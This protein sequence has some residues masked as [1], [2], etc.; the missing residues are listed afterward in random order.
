MG[1]GMTSG[2]RAYRRRA[3]A[4]FTV[5][6]LLFAGVI[7]LYFLRH[8][9]PPLQVTLALVISAAIYLG[10]YFAAGA[11]PE[12]QGAI[13]RKALII[14]FALYVLLLLNFTIFDDYFGRSVNASESGFTLSEYFE[15][16]ANLVPFR[17]I[18]RQ[19][20]ALVNGRYSVGFFIINILGNLAAL[21]PFALFLPAL[22]KK[23]KKWPRFLIVMTAIIFTIETLQFFTR[24]GSLDIDDYILNLSGAAAAFALVSTKRGKRFIE[25]IMAPNKTT[26]DKKV[27]YEE[28][29]TLQVR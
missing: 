4:C 28:D 17:M 13:M 3:A 24:T 9:S 16:K 7:C 27:I 11:Y 12:K 8:P 2:R 20:K 6:A 26:D 21:A 19:T 18:V 5:S 14:I 23:C 22:F 10:A 1:T 15:H 25:K 29:N